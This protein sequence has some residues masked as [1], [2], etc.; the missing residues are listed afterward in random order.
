MKKIYLIGIILMLLLVGCGSNNANGTSNVQTQEVTNTE[1]PQ[2]EK[3]KPTESIEPAEQQEENVVE[4]E[5]DFREGNWGDSAETI[6]EREEAELLEDSEEGLA[7]NTQVLGMNMIGCY[8]LDN[9]KL[10]QGIYI[11]Q[12]YYQD[13]NE[14]IETYHKLQDGL[15]EKY[16]EPKSDDMIWN[17]VIYDK[18]EPEK[19]GMAVVMGELQ[20]AS[21]WYTADNKTRIELYL[22]GEGLKANLSLGYTDI[23]HQ[24]EPQNETD[25]SGL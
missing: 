22:S 21:M 3:I 1:T 19:Y 16:G 11:L 2:E 20:Y 9:N 25:L 14:Y 15:K 18:D 13:E 24:E 23:S 7:Y 6:K 5:R 8:L 12:D 4:E 17:N 10:Y